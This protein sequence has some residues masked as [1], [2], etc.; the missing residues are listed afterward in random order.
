MSV[1]EVDLT[2]AVCDLA[3]QAGFARAAV[4]PAGDL[5]CSEKFDEWLE[6]GWHGEMAYMTRNQAVRKRP[7]LLVDGARSVLVLAVGYAPAADSAQSGPGYVARYARGRDYHRVLKRRCRE[8]MD[9]IRQ[10]APDFSGRAFVDTAPVMERSLAA[11]AGLGW[12]G[13]NGCLLIDGLGSY[14]V[15]CEIISNL[16]LIP[17][18][19]VERA[20]GQCDACIRACPTGALADGG[21]VDSRKCL[22][23]LTIEYSGPATETMRRCNRGLFG[24]DLCQE[25]CPHN[26]DLPAGDAE[27]LSAPGSQ[28]A[29]DLAD[30]LAWGPDDWDLATRGRAIRR[31]NYRMFM[32]NAITA[33][34]MGI[35]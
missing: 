28:A 15:L 12:I 27:L 11:A 18:R 35:T 23:Y 32:R 29:M 3:I 21:L 13:S 1:S 8:L 34:Q 16:P 17:G 22:S 30:V 7:D 4:A 10:I 31:A 33:R 24:C 6:R 14:V 25:V 5:G 26:R 20:C 9:N 2:A 19:P